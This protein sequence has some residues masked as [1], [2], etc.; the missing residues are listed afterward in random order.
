VAAEVAGRVGLASAPEL[1]RLIDAAAEPDVRRAALRA[2]ARS[3]SSDSAVAERLRAVAFD[4]EAASPELAGLAALALAARGRGAEVAELVMT[5]LSSADERVRWQALTVAGQVGVPGAVPKL[6]ALLGGRSRAARAERLA[7]ALARGPAAA[8]SGAPARAALGALT[9][10]LRAA[11]AA[12]RAAC[13]Q[14]ISVAAHAGVSAPAS[15]RQLVRLLRDPDEQVR[16]AAALGAARLAP[17]R[18][19]RDQA[20]LGREKSDVVLVAVA[21]GLGGV[22]GKAAVDRLVQLVADARPPVRAAAAAALARHPGGAAA[23]A[24]LGDHA[25]PAVRVHALALERRPAVLRAAL[26]DE[27]PEV[28][29]AALAQLS[30]RDGAYRIIPDAARLLQAARDGS[31]DAALVAGAWLGPQSGLP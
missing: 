9:R 1:V 8:D 25:D 14:A 30:T 27:N 28:R 20:A 10:C 31:A 23:L 4:P 2:L 16:A 6:A 17:A 22:P 3:S 15:Y 24:R 12:Q 11:E 18:F 26:A 13:A 5:G 7:A 29:A 21:E 19:A